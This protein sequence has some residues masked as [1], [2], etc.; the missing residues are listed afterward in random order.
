MVWRCRVRHRSVCSQCH[1]NPAIH[2]PS[3][4]LSHYRRLDTSSHCFRLP[5][6]SAAI[7]NNFTKHNHLI[8]SPSAHKLRNWLRIGTLGERWHTNSLIQKTCMA[9]EF[10]EFT[11]FIRC[12]RDQQPTLARQGL[13][14]FFSFL[15]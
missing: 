12:Q 7:H 1:A 9:H 5:Q 4:C 8:N 2:R 15:F 14:F 11:R 10:N 13:K 3:Y 6:T